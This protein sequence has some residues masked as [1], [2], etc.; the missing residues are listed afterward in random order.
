L[1]LWD[2]ALAAYPRDE[3]R[4]ACLKLQDEDGQCVCLLLWAGWAASESRPLLPETLAHAVASARQWEHGVTGPLRAARRSLRSHG[5]PVLAETVGAAEIEA[6]RLL[7]VELEGL[8]PPPTVSAA[9]QL[10]ALVAVA[11]AWAPSPAP[12]RLDALARALA[13]ACRPPEL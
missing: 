2:F 13:S 11:S 4:E 12:E 9:D 7:L 8:A 5:H 10:K 6:E 3:V 1:K